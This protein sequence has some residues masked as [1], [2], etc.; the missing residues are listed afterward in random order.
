ML[1]AEQLKRF[2]GNVIRDCGFE[3]TTDMDRNA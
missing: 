2:G 3:A 1:V